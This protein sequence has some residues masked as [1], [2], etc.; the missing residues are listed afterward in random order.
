MITEEVKISDLA[1]QNPLFIDLI[2]SISPKL[3]SIQKE[4]IINNIGKRT[5][6][7]DA[8]NIENIAVSDLLNYIKISVGETGNLSHEEDLEL[9]NKNPNIKKPE[10]LLNINEENI[11]EIDVREDIL[12]GIDPIV[13][14]KDALAKLNEFN[15]IKMV[16]FFEPFPLY[17][18]LSKK[19]IKHFSESL[20]DM[21]KI[22]FYKV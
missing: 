18:A 2:K 16:N 21:W 19:G 5:T 13:K 17:N 11:I 10:F 22:Y 9:P 15:A 4:F 8:A 7:K 20:D 3:S 1:K 14:I 6:L 12:N